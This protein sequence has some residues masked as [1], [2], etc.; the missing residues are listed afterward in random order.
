VCIAARAK[1]KIKIK[2]GE[3]Q[4]LQTWTT[5]LDWIAFPN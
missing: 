4:D 1:K 3:A 5:F 2:M